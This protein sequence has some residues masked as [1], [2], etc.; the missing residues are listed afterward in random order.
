MLEVDGA[1]KRFGSL[2][3]LKS[4]SFAAP[5]GR[6]TALMGRNGSGKSTLMRIAVGRV[7]PDWGRVVYRGRYLRRPSLSAL[8]REGLMYS[9]QSSAL[10]RHFTLHEHLEA[11]VDRFGGRERL[12]R[13]VDAMGLA[14]LLAHR[15]DEMS[16]GER[17]RA[18]VALAMIRAPA[19][20]LMDEP[21]SGVQPKDRPL[22]AEGLRAL[23]GAGAAVVI[24]GH[25]VEDLFQVSHQVIWVTAGTSHWIG[26]PAEA[27]RHDQFRREY[28]GPGRGWVA[29]TPA[30]AP[31]GGFPP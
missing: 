14:H 22:V 26:S 10:T 23:A 19:C 28:L 7:R 15:P 17:Q 27:G 31:L 11:M 4:A 12:P 16:G 1:G 2:V 29:A 8:A 30:P 20:L 9:T 6:I 21:F 24:S 3:V 25:E 5:A 13:V 18:S